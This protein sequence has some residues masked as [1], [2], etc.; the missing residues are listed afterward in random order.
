MDTPV[1]SSPAM[2]ARSI[3]AAPRQ[4]GNSDGWTLS[5]GCSESSGSLISA[6]NAHTTTAPGDAAAIRSRAASSL[7]ESGWL[8]SIPRSRAVSRTGG[9]ASLRPRPRGRSGRVTTS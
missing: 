4:R 6:P 7:T 2:I 5:I 8:V 9:E 1:A 3:G